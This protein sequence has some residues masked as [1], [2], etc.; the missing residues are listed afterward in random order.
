MISMSK[1][2][3]NLNIAIILYIQQNMV[4]TECMTPKTVFYWRNIKE[5]MLLVAHLHEILS[6][7]LQPHI[8]KEENA[9]KHG[10]K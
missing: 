1:P 3:T 7:L 4:T 8:C 10:G 6:V 5:S 2:I 9:W